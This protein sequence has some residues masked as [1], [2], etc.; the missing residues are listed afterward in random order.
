MSPIIALARVLTVWCWLGGV[1]SSAE[2]EFDWQ[3]ELSLE[4]LEDRSG[5]QYLLVN[6]NDPAEVRASVEEYRHVIL[7]SKIDRKS[8]ET[9][10]DYQAVH[11]DFLSEITK[12]Y[13][14]EEEEDKVSVSTE[15]IGTKEKKS[16]STEEVGSNESVLNIDDLN[17]WTILEKL[18]EV[19]NIIETINLGHKSTENIVRKECQSGILFSGQSLLYLS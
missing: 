2:Y 5:D 19:K 14:S 12:K 3:N 8:R 4:H 11:N 16:K 13:D 15:K 7:T 9:L 10:E 1:K 6:S 17:N 18:E